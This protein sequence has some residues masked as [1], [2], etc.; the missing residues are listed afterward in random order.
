[1]WQTESLTWEG[2]VESCWKNYGAHLVEIKD[3]EQEDFLR[4]VYFFVC[5][6]LFVCWKNYGAHLVEEEQDLL[7]FVC[8]FVCFSVCF[9]VYLFVCLFAFV[10]LFVIVFVFVGSGRL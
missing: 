5:V 4:F 6:C 3:K 8:L 1:M 2:A 9:C 7:R 10:C